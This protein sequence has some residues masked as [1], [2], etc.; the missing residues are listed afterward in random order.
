[1]KIF[2]KGLT[3]KILAQVPQFQKEDCLFAMGYVN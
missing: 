2:R 1:M 3:I